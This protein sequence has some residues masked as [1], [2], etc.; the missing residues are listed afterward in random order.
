MGAYLTWDP[1]PTRTDAD[2]NCISN[3]R[4]E[5]IGY[6]E[7]AG[8]LVYLLQQMRARGESGVALKD[9]SSEAP[10]APIGADR[11]TGLLR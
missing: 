5:G 10:T 1:G 6:L 3:I 9:E 8:K 2:R 4:P 7:A 11:G